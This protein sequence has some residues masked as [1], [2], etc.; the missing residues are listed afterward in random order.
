ME[1]SSQLK[2]PAPHEIKDEIDPGISFTL[3][4]PQAYVTRWLMEE[5]KAVRREHLSRSGHRTKAPRLVMGEGGMGRIRRKNT[6]IVTHNLLWEMSQVVD[7]RRRI[8]IP[9]HVAR[10][11][12]IGR[13]DRVVFEKVGDRFAI[14]KAGT[15]N[16]K[17]EEVMDHDPERTAKPEDVSPSEMK[18]IWR[19]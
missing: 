1:A 4:Y 3:I 10:A 5:A 2:L 9:K 13:G 12:G 14:A 17:L 16:R 11:L 18:G 15:R 8:V 19:G 7:E 6:Y